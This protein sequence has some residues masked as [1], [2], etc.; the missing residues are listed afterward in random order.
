MGVGRGIAEME[1]GDGAVGGLGVTTVS[2]NDRY[3]RKADL[4]ITF[5]NPFCLSTTSRN[6]T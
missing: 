1:I 6:S 4:T 3:E 5:A 2:V